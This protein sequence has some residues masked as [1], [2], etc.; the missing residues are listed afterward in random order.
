MRDEGG[1]KEGIISLGLHPVFCS[2]F[3]GLHQLLCLPLTR[4][5]E[6]QSQK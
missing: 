4:V 2:A 3:A 5:N 6:V 1:K